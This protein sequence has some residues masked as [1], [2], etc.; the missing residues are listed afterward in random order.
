MLRLTTGF[1]AICSC[2][3]L[4]ARAYAN[5]PSAENVAAVKACTGLTAKSANL[6]VWTGRGRWT[7]C[8]RGAKIS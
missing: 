2:L 6:I 1:A 5:E 8:G 7:A 4:G 3:V